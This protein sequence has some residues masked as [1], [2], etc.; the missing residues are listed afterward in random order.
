[1][2]TDEPPQLERFTHADA[3]NLGQRLVERC[4]RDSFPV[5]ISIVLGTQ[6]VFHAA[7]AG[8]S[9]DNDAWVARKIEVVRRF[10]RS[11]QAVH[12]RYAKNDPDFLEHFGLSRTTHAAAGGAVPIRV[13]GALVGVL[14]ISGLDSD[15]DHQLAV[16]ALADHASHSTVD[17]FVA[18]L[19]GDS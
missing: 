2:P 19:K 4:L 16:D 14:A 11:S 18:D 12:E 1:M 5:T 15:T 7:L 10:D 8:T 13:G 17:E 6:R 3:W 9:A